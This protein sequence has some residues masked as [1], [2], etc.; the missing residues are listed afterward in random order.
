MR[1]TTLRPLRAVLLVAGL[2][3]A[4]CGRVGY[5]EAHTLEAGMIDGGPPQ[6]EAGMIDGGPPQGEGG[7][8]E[9][10]SLEGGAPDAET[11]REGSVCLVPGETRTTAGGSCCTCADAGGLCGFRWACADT[12]PGASC[13]ARPPGVGEAC[14]FTGSADVCGYCTPEAESYYC[15]SVGSWDVISHACL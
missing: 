13:P 2:V 8:P 11:P 6:G 7:T 10:G 12:T 15:S 5:D 1:A 3:S 14:M 4:D 9:G